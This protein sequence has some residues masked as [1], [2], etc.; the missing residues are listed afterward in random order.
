MLHLR[1]LRVAIFVCGG[2]EIDLRQSLMVLFPLRNAP[3]PTSTT[4]TGSRPA[5]WTGTET[6]AGTETWTLW[7]ALSGMPDRI[8]SSPTNS[9]P[10]WL[11]IRPPA[12][13]TACSC[14]STISTQMSGPISWSWDGSTSTKPIG[15]RTPK[16]PRGCGRSTSSS[17]GFKA[18]RRP[19][20]ICR[21]RTPR[22]GLPLA[23]PIQLGRP[24]LVQADRAAAVSSRDEGSRI[25]PVLSRDRRHRRR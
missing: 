10:P 23:E 20:R 24:R 22:V 6:W 9:I 1:L 15:T 5:T 25:Q 21:G 4:A 8:S 14:T 7:Q 17:T 18:R 2:C 16:A 11:L 19:S 13:A 12:R 3:S